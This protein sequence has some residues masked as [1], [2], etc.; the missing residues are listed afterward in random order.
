M[1]SLLIL[2]AQEA[3]QSQAYKI[4][5]EL[6]YFV[7]SNFWTIITVAVVLL[8]AILYLAFFRRKRKNNWG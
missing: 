2:A 5:Y 3:E 6:G 1:H 8:A 4:G 7:G